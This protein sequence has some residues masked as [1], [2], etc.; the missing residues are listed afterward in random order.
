MGVSE[1]LAF[2]AG[3]TRGSG[4]SGSSWASGTR[5]RATGGTAKSASSA[6]AAAPRIGVDTRD[7]EPGLNYQC[8]GEP[9]EGVAVLA[10]FDVRDS[11]LAGRLT[12]LESEMASLP[13]IESMCRSGRA[14]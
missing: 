11:C 2:V 3:R 8:E 14:S 4:R 12:P 9:P 6:T 13:K 5:C 7:G 1:V 10:G